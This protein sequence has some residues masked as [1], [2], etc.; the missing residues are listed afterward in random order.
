MILIT[1]GT[2]TNVNPLLTTNTLSIASVL[3]NG[4]GA[5]T[6][7]G[8]GLLVLSG[9]NT[10][11]GA[12]I[13]N[14]GVVRASGTNTQTLGVPAAGTIHILRQNTS[15][16]VNAAGATVAPYTGAPSTI[17]TLVSAP[18]TGAGSITTTASG[19][20][21]IQLGTAASSATTAVFSGVISDGSGTMTVIRNGTAAGVQALT[22][23]NT[24]T[25][26]HRHHRRYSAG[27]V[28]G[29]RQRAQLHRRF[30]Q[31]GGQSR[32]QRRHVALPRDER[33]RVLTHANAV[34]IDRPA[35]HARRQ[36][37]DRF[38]GNVRQQ[39]FDDARRGDVQSRHAHLQQHQRVSLPA[40]GLAR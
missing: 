32:V 18:I 34:G 7:S 35:V 9:Q 21:A 22:G 28:A 12:L 23:L 39:Y 2:G 20:Q 3:N 16:D 13:V 19:A 11:T 40:A 38:V 5:V 24:Y 31:C 36:R 26:R 17:R 6:K 33:H 37:H 8:S 25:V 15:L 10:F 29:K 4:T 1:G 30:E 27:D 14:E